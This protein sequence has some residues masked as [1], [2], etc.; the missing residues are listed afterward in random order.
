MTTAAFLP[1]PM[2]PYICLLWLEIA[3]N[4]WLEEVDTLYVLL[5]G[6]TEKVVAEFLKRKFEEVPNAV[7]EYIPGMIQ[8]GTSLALMTKKAKEDLVMF[9]E[10]DGF[11]FKK[12]LVKKYFEIIESGEYDV[13]GSGRTSSSME[14]QRIVAKKCNVDLMVPGDAGV[15]FWPNFFFAKRVDLLK[16]DLDFNAKG[17]SKGDYIKELDWVVEPDS[18][19]ARGDTFV[20]GSIQLRALGLKCLNIPQYHLHPEWEAEKANKVNVWDGQA[21]WLHAG[22]L[23]GSLYGIL[24]DSVGNPLAFR[25]L[26]LAP[27]EEGWKLP[28]Y[29]TSKQEKQEFEKRC[30]FYLLAWDR[31][32]GEP[33]L[34]GFAEPYRIAVERVIEQFELDRQSIQLFVE[35]LTRIFKENGALK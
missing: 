2:D 29:A 9:V 21:G 24:T 14:I 8:H 12:G 31:Y 20:W 7:V 22:S 17:W 10:D 3:R 16:T 33:G 32:R 25:D 27:R 30:A 15:A 28:S 19:M 18:D 11:I 6:D 5:N 13:I 34:D 23:S 4:T 26:P 35:E 1:T